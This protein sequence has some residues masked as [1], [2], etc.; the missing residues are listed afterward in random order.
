MST[1]CRRDDSN[2]VA[3]G[4]RRRYALALMT[5]CAGLAAAADNEPGSGLEE[6][7]V[8]ARYAEENLQSTPLAITALDADALEQL[9]TSNI[10]DVA[11]SVPN[12]TIM[13][14][15]S[16][17]GK[18]AQAFI[19]GV[20]QVNFNFAFEPAVGFYVDDV[21]HG[22]VFGSLFELDDIAGVEILRGPQ[23]TLFGK[24]NE[25]GAIRISTPQP[26]GDD[27]GYLE[28]GFGNYDQQRLRGA[29]N[30]TLVPDKLFMRVS[31][32]L[33]QSD[34]WFT[35][36]DYACLHPESAGNLRPLTAAADCKLGT[37]GAEK[38]NTGRLG[39]RY[40]ASEDLEVILRADLMDDRSEA[41]P[42]KL[43]A[44]NNAPGTGLNNYNNNVAIPLFG[45]PLDSRFITDSPYTSYATYQDASTGISVPNISTN[46]AWGVSAVVNWSLPGGL[47]IKNVAGY[48]DFDGEFAINGAE[49]P[50]P[51]FI[52]LQQP[53]HHQF[54]EELTLSG[55]LLNE[56][57][58]WTVG[59][60]YYDAR[61]TQAGTVVLPALQIV[62]PLG[63]DSP[64][65]PNGLYGLNFLLNDPVESGDTSGFVH[66]VFRATDRLSIEAGIRYTRQEKTY[67]FVRTALPTNPPNPLFPPGQ[68][69]GGLFHVSARALT[70]R[71]DPKVALQFEWRPQLMTYVQV[72]TGYKGAGIN[73]QPV[74]PEDVQPFGAE[75]L[76]SYEIG[77]KGQWFEDRLRVN[78][79]VF[80]S[81]YKD[82]Q[83]NNFTANGSNRT[84][85][86]GQ[87]HINGIEL[88]LNAAPV[89]GLLVNVGV[90]YLDFETKD[91]GLAANAPPAFA[92]T[93]DTLPPYVPELKLNAGLQYSINLGAAGTLT[94]RVDWNY[95]SKVYNDAP[96]S[97]ETLQEAYGLVNARIAFESA[98]QNWTLAIEGRN[99]L[100]EEY[101]VNMSNFLPS[102]GTLD[103]QPGKP[104]MIL[105]TVKRT[106]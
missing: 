10:V 31:G 83:L 69:V 41:D 47:R 70:E 11:A 89:P 33:S 62:P 94:P 65:A 50:V 60:F 82:L 72:A 101:Y 52:I 81:N 15:G 17:Y 64:F 79:A 66:S 39:L 13:T 16:T 97:P 21:Y 73:S 78:T 76:T 14:G 96:N 90:G 105:G 46:H 67:T 91:L 26:S 48:R 87:V 104:R 3:R 20:G 32:G 8:T 25:G 12:V 4:M 36:Y 74:F 56:K 5:G 58:E 7:V 95:Q 98:D 43:L 45:V 106:F 27:E 63:P 71:W 23:G 22:T 34:G 80:H 19:R 38:I 1:G 86:T 28:L 49:G 24:S 18:S 55:A 100:D 54:S 99:L 40:V 37:T 53:S 85:N 59:G 61:S 77:L 2:L 75:D 29:L 51:T 42:T 92:P 103:A 57:L 30:M 44:V 6:V 9:G 84:V 35:R 102:Y 68:P 93:L 88:E